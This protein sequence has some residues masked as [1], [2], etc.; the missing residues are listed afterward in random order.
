MVICSVMCG[1]GG[2]EAEM[3]QIYSE[4][5]LSL[6]EMMKFIGYFRQTSEEERKKK[7][8]VSASSAELSSFNISHLICSEFK[9]SSPKT[10][11]SVREQ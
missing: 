1:Y 9:A 10:A 8:I 7:R 6:V 5:F 4:A 11:H 2:V 3:K